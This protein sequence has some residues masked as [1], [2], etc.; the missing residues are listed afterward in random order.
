MIRL[1][2]VWLIVITYAS[3][4]LHTRFILQLGYMYIN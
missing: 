1:A 4:R 3:I 2:K